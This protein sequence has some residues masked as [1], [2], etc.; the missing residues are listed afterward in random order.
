VPSNNQIDV[1][2]SIDTPQADVAALAKLTEALKSIPGAKGGGG[3]TI[4]QTF[5][6]ATEAG[7]WGKETAAAQEAI[8]GKIG[9]VRVQA[10]DGGFQA[11][12]DV[13]DEAQKKAFNPGGA[14]AAIAT[15][16]G[17]A[18]GIFKS[19]LGMSKI[20]QTFM[21]TTGKIL[22]TAVDL[23]LAPLMPFF[24]RIMVW[25]IQTVFPIA[26]T[27]GDW[28]GGLSK[29]ELAAT[30]VGG[31]V[32]LKF[33]PTVLVAAGKAL[34]AALLNKMDWSAFGKNVTTGISNAATTLKNWGLTVGGY[35][36]EGLIKVTDALKPIGT[37][38][39]D[40]ACA[41]FK[42]GKTV[43][44]TIGTAIGNAACAA[45]KA[46]KTVLTTIG[47][48]I[49]NAACAAFNAGRKVLSTIGTAIGNAACAAFNAGKTVMMTVGRAIGNAIVTAYEKGKAAMTRIGTAIG[50]A[51]ATGLRVS[52][53]W[54]A[55]GG[56]VATAIGAA[57]IGAAIGY[58]MWRSYKAHEAGKDLF[59]GLSVPETFK[60]LTE[61]YAIPTESALALSDAVAGVGQTGR[62]AGRIATSEDAFAN[63]LESWGDIAKLAPSSADMR[64]FAE[65]FDRLSKGEAGFIISQLTNLSE[66]RMA[67]LQVE[68]DRRTAADEWKYSSILRSGA[69]AQGTTVS[70]GYSLKNQPIFQGFTP[71]LDYLAESYAG[72]LQMRSYLDEVF[73]P[74]G[75][76]TKTVFDLSTLFSFG[77]VPSY[78]VKKDEISQQ[79][80]EVAYAVML[81]RDPETA[82]TFISSEERERW[83]LGSKGA[84]EVGTPAFNQAVTIYINAMAKDWEGDPQILNEV[85]ALLNGKV[86]Q[87]SVFNWPE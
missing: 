36:K 81:R 8:T 28:L 62:W 7:K 78:K 21:G 71:K 53:A 49:G 69:E 52:P 56:V 83:G 77:L 74:E 40:A 58:A 42:A 48:A 51:I 22:G 23:M 59:K 25:L 45:F 10:K 37:A 17:V 16:M 76:F 54:M 26:T 19:L 2:V 63:F 61:Q 64:F 55:I 72:S 24:M 66:G 33:G 13:G 30:L 75:T 73:G 43:L 1:N 50:G 47:T 5:G 38:I 67:Q 14:I 34:G 11:S 27:L 41:A 20:F 15:G 82:L 57:A 84:T 87:G 12:V 4:Q 29:K 80:W 6:T 79:M 44:T 70:Q 46:G 65:A 31:Y 85:I 86:K 9:G 3:G 32:A 39:G 35:I 60:V 18:V 68:M